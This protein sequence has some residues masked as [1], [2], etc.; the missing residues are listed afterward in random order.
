MRGYPLKICQIPWGRNPHLVIQHPADPDILYQQNQ[1][2]I[3]KLN[4]KSR[5]WERIGTN[6]DVGDIG[7]SLC[8][9]PRD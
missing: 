4:L 9:H 8:V 1:G 6:I 5:V 3:F 2:G 7:F